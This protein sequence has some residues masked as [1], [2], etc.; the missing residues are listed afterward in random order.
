M[1]MKFYKE[2]FLKHDKDPNEIIKSL[3]DYGEGKW[4][5]YNGREWWM[6]C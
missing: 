1:A 2:K 3:K 5:R 4:Q 6:V